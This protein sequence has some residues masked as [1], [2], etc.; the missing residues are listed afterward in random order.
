[1][2]YEHVVSFASRLDW[3]VLA[4]YL[5]SLWDAKES[6]ERGC[7]CPLWGLPAKLGHQLYFSGPCEEGLFKVV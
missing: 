1:M 3:L 6:F 4:G 7:R 2:G 5:N